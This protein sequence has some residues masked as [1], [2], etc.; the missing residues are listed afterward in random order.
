MTKTRLRI[1]SD[2]MDP[3][4]RQ[5]GGR[6]GARVRELS[7]WPL[8]AVGA[9]AALGCGGRHADD[10][11]TATVRAA[12][13]DP[14]GV[15]LLAPC[16]MKTGTTEWWATFG[17]ESATPQPVV[18]PVGTTNTFSPSPTD[19][20]QPTRFD[21]GLHARA[22]SV[23][24]DGSPLRWTLGTRTVTAQS[25]SPVCALAGS[26]TAP[27]LA[28]FALYA[29]TDVRLDRVT[30]R[31]G[32]V[33]VAGVGQMTDGRDEVS[34]EPD[35][36]V[37]PTRRVFG[38]TVDLRARAVM[39]TIY[40]SRLDNQGGSYT[41]IGAFPAKMPPLPVLDPVVPGTTPVTVA[42]G[43][44]RTLAPGSWGAVQV[45][46]TLTLTGGTYQ[47]ASLDIWNS[48]RVEAAAGVRLRIKGHLYLG[49]SARLRTNPVGSARDLLVD[50][51]GGDS[52]TAVLVD[53]DTEIHALV[54]APTGLIQLH[55]RAVAKGALVAREI[56]LDADARVIFES[57]FA[58]PL[59]D[60]LAALQ[61]TQDQL[62]AG[63]D[64]QDLPHTV[65]STAC[66][67]P[68]ASSCEVSFIALA[69]FDRRTAAKR[70]LAGT[71]TP[72]QYLWISR[73]RSRKLL[74]AEKDPTWAA[75][76]CVGDADGDLV[77]NDRDA[78]AGTPPLT[79]TDDRGCTDSTLPPAPDP[80]KT[81][82]N[83][84]TGGFLLSVGCDGAPE[85]F[86]PRVT[87]VCL[88][89]PN[90]RFLF[91]VT[92]DARQPT[93]CMTWYQMNTSVVEQYEPREKFHA[94]L[95]FEKGQA[96]T[97]TA[98]T[99]TLPLPLTCTPGHEDPGDGRSWPCDEANGDAYD[100]II[101]AR[102]VNGNGMQ[103]P[104][105]QS[106]QFPFHLCQ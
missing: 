4:G 91:T 40:T 72:A 36:K 65:A 103:S 81:K 98:T 25:S 69:N 99:V 54:S 66:L 8:L 14:S 82:R 83:L 41:S 95:G 48:G 33:G 26:A 29:Q 47:F 92:K 55:P 90:L 71:F 59:K 70:L 32:D 57:G 7:Q 105:G 74:R 97:E 13:V 37:D 27:I 43:T 1:T 10:G 60:C 2:T 61:V 5:P 6:R 30:V 22:F 17:Y 46:G 106:R 3:R 100:V 44:A 28:Q 80:D 53:S 31:G 34:L 85:P 64:I 63:K 104:W 45:T 88:D 50:V 93:R 67:A 73:D 78:C 11:P 15:T 49:P 9:L 18:V 39:G 52:Q 24:F 87:D 68:D 86:P 20:G 62:V 89:R 35:G 94:L 51:A 58:L 84:A 42:Q 56:R 16:V 38:K 75:A 12:V 79:A 102:T 96:V 21:P 76:F 101:A 77:P 19:R 23:Q